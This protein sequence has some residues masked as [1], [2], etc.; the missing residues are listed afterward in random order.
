MHHGVGETIMDKAGW[1]IKK[2]FINGAWIF[3][4]SIGFILLV[5]PTYEAMNSEASSDGEKRSVDQGGAVTAIIEDKAFSTHLAGGSTG[6]TLSKYYSRREYLGSPPEIP[7]PDKVHGN[8]LECLI[9]HADGGWTGLL[10]RRTPVTPHPEMTGCRQ[11]HVSPVTDVLFQD[12][13]WQSLPP[14][15]LGRSYL[16]GSPPPIP[17]DLQMRENCNACH[18]GPG[19]LMAVRMKHE[20]R[21]ICRQCHLPESSME[22]FRR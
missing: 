15:R 9:C 2:I 20:W 4:V 6:R 5:A 16:P 19:T 11:C 3:L 10:Q 8:D 21:G 17:H 12:T 14:P 1:R 22:F 7:H 13:D 18:V